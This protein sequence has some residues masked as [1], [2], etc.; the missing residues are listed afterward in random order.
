MRNA[1]WL[2]AS[3]FGMAACCLASGAQAQQVLITSKSPYWKVGVPDQALSKDCAFRRF[4]MTE[5]GRYVLR[6]VGKTGPGVLGVAKGAGLNLYD[7]DH[8]AKPNEDYF[9]Y[10]YGTTSCA[11]FVGGRGK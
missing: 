5:P 1:G 7:P 9:F 2:A 6:F 11:V 3:V 8:H 4:G 10:A